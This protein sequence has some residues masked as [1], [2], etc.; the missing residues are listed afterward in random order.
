LQFNNDNTPRDPGTDELEHC[1]AHLEA[2]LQRLKPKVLIIQGRETYRA[3]AGT[4]A[5]VKLNRVID[6]T[7]AGTKY[8]AVVIPGGNTM[9][10][11]PAVLLTA[12]E[13]ITKAL[14]IAQNGEA[15]I[16]H[17]ARWKV[18]PKITYCDT[19]EKVEALVEYLLHG[20][21]ANDSVAV[22]VE[23]KN[24][25]ARYGNNLVMLQFC[26]DPRKE[27]WVVPYQY[28]HGPFADEDLPAIRAALK[29]LFTEK[30]NFKYWLTHGGQFEQLQVM[31]FITDGKTF[32]NA[33]M[34]DTMALAYLMNENR[35]E[36]YELLE[37]GLSLKDLTPEMCGRDVYELDTI[38]ARR[39][40]EL[41]KLPPDKLIPYAADDVINTQ[42][43]F[44]YMRICGRT[45]GEWDSTIKLAEFLCSGTFRLFAKVKRN[46]LFANLKHLRV[47]AS[48]NSPILQRM[49][50]IKR[51]MM[52][53]DAVQ[54]TN[55]R[56]AADQSGNQQPIFGTK[57]YPYV[58]QI[59]KPAHLQALFFETMGLEPLKPKIGKVNDTPSVDKAFYETYAEHHEEVKLVQEYVSL[60]KLATSY[61]NNILEFVDPNATKSDD[62]QW[63]NIDTSTDSRVR[64][65]FGFTNTVTGRP[66]C[67]KPNIQN[68]PRAENY[69]KSQI[70]NMFAAQ[71]SY[72]TYEPGKPVE[73]VLMQLDFSAAEV[74]WW[75]ILAADEILKKTAKLS[76][77]IHSQTASQMF[78]VAL[79]KVD[80]PMRQKTKAIV[81]ALLYGGGPKLIAAR[82]K[83]NDIDEVVR[84]C[85]QFAQKFPQGNK[86]LKKIEQFAAENL[87][88]ASP[89]GRKRHLLQFLTG[90]Q[91]VEA[92]ASRFARNAPIQAAASDGCLIGAQIWSD[93]IEDNGKDWKIV[94]IVH[95]SCVTEI[96]IT[97]VKEAVEQ[98]HKCFTVRMMNRIREVWGV[99]FICPLEVEFD[100]GVRWGEMRGWEWL[101]E[102]LDNII[103]WL[104]RGGWA[105]ENVDKIAAKA[106]ESQQQTAG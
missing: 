35:V 9:V 38:A 27:A 47:L 64:P 75:A 76:G 62:P 70:K 65:D 46:G 78:G 81:F 26:V 13:G 5:S 72:G 103:A 33:P 99:D 41:Y 1:R 89:M 79:D 39:A 7:V 32:K 66:S 11:Y 101:P 91:D 40:G 34:I 83:T 59:N 16:H 10:K 14:D 2:D 82:L 51:L 18:A 19:V 25:N 29:R 24:L 36:I 54:R 30:P 88:V 104:G 69:A 12:L 57:T 85:Q 106:V 105:D 15:S 56:L 80:K 77:D 96:P 20:T 97:D 3:M 95:D 43:I 23:T 84:M 17:P 102:E 48:S 53:S 98:A 71:Q 50:E 4:T 52:K 74:R 22:D 60:K 92:Q 31:E 67:I 87:F 93:W 58:F 37:Q 42:L 61:T 63:S 28:M 6:I 90:M 100:F 68:V 45:S 49:D 55:K 94:N 21:E 8:P 73:R 86:W 44:R